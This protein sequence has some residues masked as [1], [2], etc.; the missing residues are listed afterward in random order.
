VTAVALL[1]VALAVP[2]PAALARKVQASYERTTDLTAHFVQTYRYAAFGKSQ[3]SKGVLKVKRPGRMR[4]D[5][6]EP[7]P[8]TV[9]VVGSR[10]V[11]WEPEVEQ[12]YVDEHFDASAMSAAVTFLLGTGSLVREFELGVDEE[13]WLRCTPRRP[14]PRVVSV[15]LQVGADG[16]V[17]AT[18][19]R[20][21]QGNVNEIRFEG[22]RRN[23]GLP[24]AAFEV[25]IPEGARRLGAK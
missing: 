1:A 15:S 25:K 3:V 18:R 8:K 17:T 9:A 2:D 11:Q 19:V 7:S 13:G 22:I 24:D 4:W 20:D 10:L 5:Y 16:E 14:D 23:T 21:E 12:A 6:Q